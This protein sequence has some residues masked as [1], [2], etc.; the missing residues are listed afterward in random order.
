M[1]LKIAVK[2]AFE[3]F[4][5]P[6]FLIITTLLFLRRNRPM[7]NGFKKINCA[8]HDFTLKDEATT[9]NIGQTTGFSWR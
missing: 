2:D 5:I 3:K 4:A 7:N 1:G 9:I 6:T 8:L